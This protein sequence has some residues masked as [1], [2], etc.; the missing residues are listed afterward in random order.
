[1]IGNRNRS[2]VDEFFTR[3]RHESL[4]VYYINR[5]CFGLPKRNTRKNSDRMFLF[6]QTLREMLRV[7]MKILRAMI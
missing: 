6:K 1:M 2:Q 7:S 3:G 4:A 5:S